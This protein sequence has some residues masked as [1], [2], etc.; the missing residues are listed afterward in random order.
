MSKETNIWKPKRILALILYYGFARFLPVSYNPLGLGL[1]R[2]IRGLLCQ[3]IFRKCGRRINVEKGAYFGYGYNVQI[4]DNSG[5]GVNACI[6]GGADVVIGNNVMMAPEVVILTLNHEFES[7]TE[8]MMA[9]GY[10][11]A[12]V[13][14][15]DDVWIGMR[16]LIVP[17]VKIGKGSIVAAG[18]V[19]TKDVPP[20]TVV[21]GNPARVIKSRR[22]VS[23]SGQHKIE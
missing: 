4:G 19:V 23:S 13:I 7:N 10:R 5:I 8:S 15:E 21:G 9:Q 17:G 16:A 14:I 6:M 1:P 12:P 2:P 11:W 20:Y 22:V 18:S 3:Q